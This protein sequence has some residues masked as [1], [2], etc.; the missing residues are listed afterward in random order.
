ML[1]RGAQW[2]TVDLA[3]GGQSNYNASTKMNGIVSFAN[4]RNWLTHG[5]LAGFI[6]E[7]NDFDKRTQ[8][9]TFAAGVSYLNE[10]SA[11][12]VFDPDQ[13]DAIMLGRPVYGVFVRNLAVEANIDLEYVSVG[14]TEQ[15]CLS[16]VARFEAGFDNAKA[17]GINITELLICNPHKSLGQFQ[18]QGHPSGD[19][20]LRETNRDGR[21]SHRLLTNLFHTAGV[22]MSTGKG[23]GAPS[24]ERFRLVFCV[25]S[26][27]LKEG[28]KR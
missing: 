3:L 9:I 15:S 25:D 6:N 2:A 4:A 16:I 17:W 26:D 22:P 5:D 1:R 21:I 8:D 20:T 28:I 18:F 13:N 19:A 10:A 12:I 24:P 7:H 23:Y 27:T 14:D 11:L